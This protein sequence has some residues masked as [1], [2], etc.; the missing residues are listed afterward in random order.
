MKEQ[1]DTTKS[2]RK[3]G[4][5][6]NTFSRLKRS[7]K[8]DKSKSGTRGVD[9]SEAANQAES[10][11]NRDKSETKNQARLSHT[12]TRTTIISLQKESLQLTN[13]NAKLR[14][15]LNR[16]NDDHKRLKHEILKQRVKFQ[17][18]TND[19]QQQIDSMKQKLAVAESGKTQAGMSPKL[20]QAK[21]MSI[22]DLSP[23]LV[24][25]AGNVVPLDKGD[26]LKQEKGSEKEEGLG[27]L[28]WQPPES[29]S[30]DSDEDDSA[31]LSRDKKVVRRFIS[32]DPR[33]S[34]ESQKRSASRSGSGEHHR[35]HTVLLRGRR[36][37]L[38]LEDHRG[39]KD[40]HRKST[41]VKVGSLSEGNQLFDFVRQE[42]MSEWCKTFR[43]SDPRHQILSFFD[44]MAQEGADN[45][46][47]G[48]NPHM[49]SP[50]L[51]MFN[52]ASVFTVWRPT[53]LDAI[54]RMMLGEG[55]GK[56]LDIKGKSAKKGKLSGYV[57]YLQ[58]YEEAHKKM[59]ST[60]PKDGKIK[61]FFKRE[62]ARNQVV[63]ELNTL[64]QEMMEVFV[65]AK[66]VVEEDEADDDVMEWH[67]QKLVWEM[68]DTQ[69][70]LIDDYASSVYGMLVPERLF[71]EGIVVRQDI[72]RE[73]GSRN[74][75]GRP[76][77]PNFQNMNSLSLRKEPK[78]GG[79]KTVILQYEAPGEEN[80]NPM[81]P[82][83]LVMAYEEDN[84]I[85]PVVSD[86]DC[87]IV[88]TRG[89]RYEEPMEEDQLN[90]LKWCV[91]QIETVLDSGA[92]SKS[93]TS[94]WLDILKVEALK[95]YFPT[96]P[97]LGFSDPKSSNMMKH[98]INRLK[99]EGSVR[100]GAECFNYCFPQ[101]LDDEFLVICHDLPG[102]SRWCYVDE[103]GL[104]DLLSKQVDRGYT[105]PIN[106]K[107]ILCDQGWKAIYD[108]LMA[109]KSP[110]VQ[111]SLRMWYPT[112]MGLREKI[113]EIHKR[114]PNGFQRLDDNQVDEEE[115]DGTA[116]MDLAQQ[117]L[118]AYL[119]FQRAKRKLRGIFV[120]RR[121]LLGMRKGQERKLLHSEHRNLDVFHT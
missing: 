52:K 67:Y 10:N 109:S 100:H 55:V 4:I 121:L 106:P 73:K 115:Q 59:V 14:E 93:W 120:W 20:R 50:L 94:R 99:K 84:R 79:P 15:Q 92:Q 39:M 45:L 46:D 48:F 97:P 56:G 24:D 2:R 65:K 118:R 88:G 117:E 96:P 80:P 75:T 70:D 51:R 32:E 40:V 47:M 60:H 13:E 103:V 101:E 112:E 81:D 104:Q 69:I 110:N 1:V 86:F 102:S 22:G 44:D 78:Y 25:F 89:V 5:G 64:A 119:T 16:A 27:E 63:S 17:Q 23:M 113:E 83:N 18:E 85:M 42:R 114:H 108:K 77:E 43:R 82:R 61:V 62:A 74:D 107:W 72:S 66:V 116:A 34:V 9:K 21:S 33:Q 41:I 87:F 30:T 57:P 68:T 6:L 54:R 98:A 105:F 12:D 3:R 29:L 35:R 53:S 111:D 8:R 28:P 26:G 58:I 31:L 91:D 7:F 36:Q 37:G 95:G 90:V 49:S 11:G 19:L 76:S 71:W 38:K